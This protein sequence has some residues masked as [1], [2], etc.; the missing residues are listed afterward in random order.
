RALQ[1]LRTAATSGAPFDL[2]VLD[3]KMP[4]MD[5][6][7]LARAI[8]AEGKLEAVKL[9]LL[10]SFGQKG[11][12]AEAARAGISGYLTKPVDEADRHDCLA[13]IMVGAP[14]RSA[15][16]VWCHSRRESRPPAVCRVL[17]GEDNDVNQKVAVRILERLGYRVDV[18]DNGREAVEAVARTRY[19]AV[20]MDGQMPE[21]D[22][23]E[24]TARIREREGDG[25]RIPIVAMTASAMKGDRE[26][27]LAAGM[28]DYVAKPI[29]PE[30]LL[31]VLTRWVPS[32]SAAAVA[33]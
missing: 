1:G 33:D 32:E 4:D 26:K 20:L 7:A 3:F 29:G 19:D 16:R 18:A 2:A 23:F 5:G 28:D 24:A 13:E 27:C 17:V 14:A 6:L 30:T 12:G 25:R 21:M 8:K 9:V 11:H 15:T 31:A 22:G 10:T